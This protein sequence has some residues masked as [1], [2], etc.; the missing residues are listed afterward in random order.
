MSQYKSVPFYNN[1]L[2]MSGMT[3]GNGHNHKMNVSTKLIRDL[4]NI[5][6]E[7]YINENNISDFLD[8]M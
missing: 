8:N 6:D 2:D 1:W 7:N 5:N 3:A 4:E